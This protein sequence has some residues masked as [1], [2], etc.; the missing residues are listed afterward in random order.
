MAVIGV[1]LGTYFTGYGQTETPN[2]TPPFWKVNGNSGT[3][4]GTNFVG[5]T[6]AQ[7][8]DIRTNNVLRVR[9]TQKGQIEVLNTGQSVFVGEGAGANDDL[10]FNGNVFIGYTA[11]QVN[12]TGSNNTGI[13][14]F[15]LNSNLST[16]N[17]AIGYRNLEANSTGFNNTS[18]GFSS[19]ANN[20]DGNYNTAL[21]YRCL[22]NNVS[23]SNNI[24]IGSDALSDNTADYNVG[25]GASV[26]ANNTTG[27][28]NV[29]V[30]R[31]A[32]TSNV[33]GSNNVAVGAH[34]LQSNLNGFNTA[35]GYHA[36]SITTTGYSNTAVG[37]TAGNVNMTG[38]RNTLIG[39][40][41][42]VTFTNYSNATAIGWNARVAQSNSLVLGS[43][44]GI[45]G[46][47]VTVRVGIGTTSPARALHIGN[48]TLGIRYG[49][50]STG[51]SF[52]GTPSATTDKILYADANGD[53][54]AMNAGST[55]QVL[56]YTAAGPAWSAAATTGW[57]LTGNTGTNS[58]AN[59]LGTT[60][61]VSLRIRT[62]NFER[63]VIDSFG[64][65]GIGTSTPA[66]RLHVAGTGA[67]IRYGGVSTGGVMIANATANTDKM[68][69]ANANGD[70]KAIPA[71]STNQVLTFTT[72]GPAWGATTAT[73][74]GLT[75]NALTVDGTNF[76]GTT[77]DIPFNVRINNQAAARIDRT[78]S[79]AFWG[80]QSGG[81]NNTTF[82][83]AI[84]HMAMFASSTSSGNTALG[85]FALHGGVSGQSNVAI[86]LQTLSLANTGNFN[87]AVGTNALLKNTSGS[88]NTSV[89][90]Q[91][92]YNNTTGNSNVAIGL[93]ALYNSSTLLQ[94]V[95]I[96]DSALCNNNAGN[97]RNTAVGYK[98]LQNNVSGENNTAL[99]KFAGLVVTTSNN[100]AI[101]YGALCCATT[102]GSQNTAVGS[103]VVS[104]NSTGSNNVLMGYSVP[105][106]A[107]SV[108]DKNLVLG[109][110]AG[111]LLSGNINDDN[112]F[113]GY[114]S[115]LQTSGGGNS[116]NV[117]IG[118]SALIK[119]APALGTLTNNTLVGYNAISNGNTNNTVI[120][121]N[122]QSTPSNANT[123][124]TVIGANA[125]VTATNNFI[126]G[127]TISRPQV[128]IGVTAVGKTLSGTR[129]EIASESTTD[130]ILFRY[131]G[132]G[133]PTFNFMRSQGTINA[134]T[135]II[136]GSV[137]GR[138]EFHG[139]E[140]TNWDASGYITFDVDSTPA[141]SIVPTRIRFIT[142][143]SQGA[144][145]EQ[146]R[147]D[148]RGYIGIGENNPRTQLHINGGSDAALAT[149]ESGYLMIGNE[150]STNLLFDDNE[151]MARNNSTVSNLALQ[152]EGGSVWVHQVGAVD[153]DDF[154]ITDDN[155][156]RVGIGVGQFPAYQL[157]LAL[158]SAGKPGSN[159]WI[160]VSDK[161]LKKDI[162]PFNEGL[163]VLKQV[164]PVWFSYNGKGSV[165]DTGRY[166]GII[167]QEI[168]PIAPYMV[169]TGLRKENDSTFNEYLNYDGNA[170]TYIL[171][172]SVKEQQAV[173]E[174]MKARLDKQQVEIEQLKARR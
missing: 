18:I 40:S 48:D 90:F 31:N 55:N 145:S 69:Y 91:A 71:G 140:G 72:S 47:D 133:T 163:S 49:G 157:E 24:A 77:D 171:I 166:V 153:A 51:G 43:T 150:L 144:V 57:S 143:S 121:A 107:F 110:L 29:A 19:L 58:G 164:N 6:D 118:A 152:G 162:A 38:Y 101:G 65:V 113:A 68:L 23:G 76:I 36:L 104:T 137:L 14:A 173:I 82:N 81:A 3:T 130:N 92:M 9:I 5:T 83:T 73:A 134:P 27:T 174:E 84:G 97:G 99:G 89:G 33:T 146:M 127:D 138:I 61:N 149:I 20:V 44:Q 62:G 95:A 151:I 12:V 120:G 142:Q 53:I 37:Y 123:N 79:N 161:R 25:I 147:I 39:D 129:F 10:S 32:L 172:N 128:G 4:N 156:V 165:A 21:G 34:S 8:L 139:Y 60:D 1:S 22:F 41:A 59:F 46:S 106:S 135:A 63:M 158:N 26:M 66:Q 93:R 159:A 96:G 117:V 11:G 160:I 2:P 67:A 112:V 167:A 16:A 124:T 111:N 168:Q 141:T 131:Q 115:G 114:G 17:T 126:I 98:A 109:S 70:I 35:V 78:N 74:W 52:I 108:G 119:D 88:N 169:K 85:A 54:R 30:G 102:Y 75:G 148:R 103:A 125:Q 28:L 56:T 64:N 86:G 105:V 170:M 116:Q 80:Y 42:N 136:N 154:M 50:V 45:G 122:A 155:D 15:A 94:Q 87:T 132:T 7:S 100:T 13:G